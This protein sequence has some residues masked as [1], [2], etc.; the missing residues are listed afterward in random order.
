ML[1]CTN[2]VRD[3]LSSFAVDMYSRTLMSC[4]PCEFIDRRTL[5]PRKL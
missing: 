4:A 5:P 3:L 2:P 1:S